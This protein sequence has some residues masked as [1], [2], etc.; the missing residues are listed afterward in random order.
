MYR[1]AIGFRIPIHVNDESAFTMFLTAT[2]A[3]NDANASQ[4]FALIEKLPRVV[5]G[6]L[7]ANAIPS[8]R[9]HLPPIVAS[10]DTPIGP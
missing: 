2:M 3:S 9:L 7:S 6:F 4:P 5:G 8:A 1:R 10:P